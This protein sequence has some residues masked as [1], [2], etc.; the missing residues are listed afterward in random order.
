MDDGEVQLIKISP[1]VQDAI[2]ALQKLAFDR[3][4]NRA[5]S[6]ISSFRV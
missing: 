6:Q 5:M 4:A 2:L 3:H 1:Y